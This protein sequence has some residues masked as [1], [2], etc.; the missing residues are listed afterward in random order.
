MCVELVVV[1]D[2]TDVVLVHL[3]VV[4]DLAAVTDEDGARE[5]LVQLSVDELGV[6]LPRPVGED[7][8]DGARAEPLRRDGEARLHHQLRRP[9][10]PEQRRLAPAIRAGD[11]Q[12][13]SRAET[14][15]VADRD[16]RGAQRE[17]GVVQALRR[18]GLRGARVRD[19]QRAAEPLESGGEVVASHEF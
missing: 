18:R 14:D 11:D 7:L 5:L 16:G 9:E 10:G 12:Q 1:R 17:A 6:L 19:A 15:V 8:A 2:G 3:V 4:V 13:V